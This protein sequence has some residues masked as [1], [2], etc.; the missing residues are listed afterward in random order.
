M[1]SLA[2]VAPAL[3]MSACRIQDAVIGLSEVLALSCTTADLDRTSAGII[4]TI[5]Q[6][7]GVTTPESATHGWTGAPLL[8]GTR[9]LPTS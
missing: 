8:C 3:N 9:C 2:G 7:A 6:G 4:N 5:R 1:A